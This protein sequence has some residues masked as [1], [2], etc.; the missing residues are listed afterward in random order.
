MSDRL[1]FRV[2]AAVVLAAWGV[3][4]GIYMLKPLRTASSEPRLRVVGY[5][6]FR[7]P[8]RSMEPTI[9][10]NETFI[11]SAWPYRNADPA[12]G[13]LVVFQYPADPSVVFVKRVIATGG[14]MLQVR[15]GVTFVDGKRVDE[16]Y[17]DSGNNV[18]DISRQTYAA[19]V[20]PG[21]FFVM[22]DNRDSSND[23]RFWGFAPRSHIVGKVVFVSAPNNRWRG[24]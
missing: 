8:S 19:S 7:I 17:V 22:G 18:K 5:T 21:A 12:R 20:P 9:H 15:D 3:I 4:V 14:S 2:F 16:P 6:P 11:V 13:D 10:Q 1:G 24:P 23:S